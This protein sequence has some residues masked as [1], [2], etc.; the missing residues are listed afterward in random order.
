MG[1]NEEGESG[2]K[3]RGTSTTGVKLNSGK[4]ILFGSN[5]KVFKCLRR[6]C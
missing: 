2:T 6:M 3:E 4:T 5:T 1:R